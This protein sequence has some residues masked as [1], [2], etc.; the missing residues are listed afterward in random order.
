M[1]YSPPPRSLFLPDDTDRRSKDI[2]NRV[3]RFLDWLEDTRRLWFEPDLAAYRDYLLAERSLASS[4]VVYHLSTIR[5]RYRELLDDGTL[6]EVLTALVGESIPAPQVTGHVASILVA[7]QAALDPAASRVETKP[8]P[9]KPQ[10]LRLDGYALVTLINWPLDRSDLSPLARLRDRAIL[11]LMVAT[12]IRENELCA[13]EVP[14]LYAL[15]GDMLAVHVPPGRART[16]RLIPYDDMEWAKTLVEDWR[17]A[18]EITEGPVFR[19]FYRPRSLE[20]Q[21]LRPNRLSPRA[22]EYLLQDYT[23]PVPGGKFVPIRAMDLRR[24]YARILYEA[25]VNPSEIRQR[26]GVKNANAVLDYI[27]SAD[28]SLEIPPDEDVYT[29]LRSR[30]VPSEGDG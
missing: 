17:A 8:D 4:S 30:I 19:G 23:V 27:G 12:G 2:R 15:S 6:S 20:G 1:H 24:A 22:L 3:G 28:A 18:A 25:R 13:L 11:G 7:L 14:D 16:E 26:L 9:E 10:Y 21:E 29:F 5:S